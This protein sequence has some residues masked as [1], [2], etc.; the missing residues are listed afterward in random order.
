MKHKD[1]QQ[2][3]SFQFTKTNEIPGIN[4]IKIIPAETCTCHIQ[5]L[6]ILVPWHVE[7]ER[8]TMVCP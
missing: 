1:E 8:N 7:E 2:F 5:R 3:S 4:H 6:V